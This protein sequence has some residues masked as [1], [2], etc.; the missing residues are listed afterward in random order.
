MIK[1]RLRGK[2]TSNRS[3]AFF[4]RL[5]FTGKLFIVLAGEVIFFSSYLQYD[6]N[7][8]GKARYGEKE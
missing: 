3:I 8:I 7:R 5:I 2:D 6:K 4:N 1:Y